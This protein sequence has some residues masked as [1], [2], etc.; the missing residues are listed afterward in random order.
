MSWRIIQV[1]SAQEAGSTNRVGKAWYA[2]WFLDYYNRD[3][4]DAVKS[5]WLSP[6]YMQDNKHLR[7]PIVVVLPAPGEYGF[8]FCVDRCFSDQEHG[9]RVTG[10]LEAGNLTMTPSINAHDR[11]H[12]WITNGVITDDCEG[13]KYPQHAPTN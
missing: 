2:P 9:W 7:M 13:R 3:W 1:K 5:R 8:E 11:Y 4:A 12:G 6:E 10:T